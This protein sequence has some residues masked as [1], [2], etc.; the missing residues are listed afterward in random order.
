MKYL[1]HILASLYLTGFIPTFGH[2]YAHHADPPKAPFAPP[3]WRVISS[4]ICAAFWPFY[5]SVQA[6]TPD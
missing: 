6:H 2:A 1:P 4:T 3:G 5:W